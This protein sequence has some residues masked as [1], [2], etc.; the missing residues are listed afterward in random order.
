MLP[1]GARSRAEGGQ[2][3]RRGGKGRSAL[4]TT[5][6]GEGER[7][8]VEGG[9]AGAGRRETRV[10]TVVA[11]PMR[12]VTLMSAVTSQHLPL[13][14]G[15]PPTEQARRAGQGEGDFLGAGPAR[16]SNGAANAAL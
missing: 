6:G 16:S 3:G 1:G 13:G 14:S 11:V 8:T 12:E 10:M 15:P 4:L 2:L 7:R 5:P 9:T